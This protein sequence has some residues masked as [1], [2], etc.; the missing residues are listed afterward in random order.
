MLEE[1]YKGGVKI[2]TDKWKSFN[3]FNEALYQF[4]SL[5][6]LRGTYSNLRIWNKNYE[7]QLLRF[8]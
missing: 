6:T 4:Q 8:Y 2:A 5:Y 1:E 3:K 7:K